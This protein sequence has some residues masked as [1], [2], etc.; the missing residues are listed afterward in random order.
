MVRTD[1]GKIGCGSRLDPPRQQSVF[2]I[3][4][5]SGAGE[6]SNEMATRNGK[7]KRERIPL[8]ELAFV[9]YNP[10]AITREKF[11]RLVASVREYTSTLSGWDASRG[12]RLACTI[13]VNT[14]GN[15]V[16]GGEQRIRALGELGQSW[17]HRDDITRVS[18][19]PGSALEKSLCVELNNREAQGDFTTD[20][21]AL[22]ESITADLGEETT[23]GLGLASMV[24]VLLAEAEAEKFDESDAREEESPAPRE[25]AHSQVDAIYALGDHRLICGDARRADVLARLMDGEKAD[26]LLTDP[27]YN[28]AYTGKTKDAL[29]IRNDEMDDQAFRYFLLDCFEAANAALRPGAAFY[30]WH[31]DSK[32]YEFRTACRS[33]GWTVR[34]CLIW[35]KSVMVLGRQ[36]YQW[37]H[38]PCLYGWKDGDGHTWNG[39]RK[40]TT[41]LA[42]DKPLANADHPTMKPVALFRHQIQNSTNDGD[43]VLDPFG[44]SG[45]T[46]I[47]AERL[48]RR[49]RLVELDPIYCD[50][51]RR[52]WAEFVHGDG[53][54]WQTLTPEA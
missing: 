10:R 39:G 35:E 7:S 38:E 47:A 14:N 11:R 52:R 54:D 21:V 30:I 8:S 49:A 24:E 33:A 15:R 42:F 50:V 32:G 46:A 53:C 3:D 16:I 4:R 43:L 9:S 28:V 34:Q 13:T 2:R 12:Y 26:L 17:I 48:G 44:G 23:A 1:Q 45:T 36:D 5:L 19:E 31:A 6:S 27:P 22:I 37:R 25:P 29:T 20:V 18:I 51:I 40:Q 41:I